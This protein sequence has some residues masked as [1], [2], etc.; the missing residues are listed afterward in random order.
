MKEYISCIICNSENFY[1]IYSK[2]NINI[3]KCSKCS[4]MYQN[5]RTL[6]YLINEE[7]YRENYYHVYEKIAKEQE[8]FFINRFNTILKEMP[9]GRVLDVGCGTGSFLKVAKERG[10]NIH[11][12]EV[13]SWA[14]QVLSKKL[15]IEVRKGGV[16]KAN[17]PEDYFDLI[18][19]S[20]VLEHLPNPL[21]TLE[22]IKRIMKPS[23]YLLIEVPN[24][25]NFKI[26]N[27]LLNLFLRSTKEEKFAPRSYHLY[28]FTKETLAYLLKKTGFKI[29]LLKE[30]GFGVPGREDWIFKNLNPFFRTF[31]LIAKKIQLDVRVGLGHYLLALAKKE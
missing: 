4:L 9:V 24:E 13:S 16:E 18:N 11:G 15:D 23:G 27:F 26:R 6:V 21:I 5:P 14:V 12:V 29:L 8:N 3:V 19:M 25:N 28:L 30:E 7:I 2:G 20:H 1:H 10:W 31:A 22:E 17:F